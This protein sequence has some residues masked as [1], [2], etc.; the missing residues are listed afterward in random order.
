M[1]KVMVGANMAQGVLRNYEMEG[2][3]MHF[4]FEFSGNSTI[5][6]VLPGFPAGMLDSMNKMGLD[7]IKNSVIDLNKGAIT[8]S[9]PVGK[10]TVKPKQPT[11][12]KRGKMRPIGGGGLL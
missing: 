11:T 9:E 12:E 10:E 1:L 5:D 2:T 4:R 7:K 3:D 8:L 6:F